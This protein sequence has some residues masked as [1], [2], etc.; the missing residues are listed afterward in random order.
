MACHG[1]SLTIGEKMKNKECGAKNW[2]DV[3]GE[4]GHGRTKKETLRTTPAG[5]CRASVQE[6][7]LS[8]GKE[9]S[10]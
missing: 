9:K 6:G 3:E 2:T 10:C 1:T 8:M 5:R 4:G 7:K